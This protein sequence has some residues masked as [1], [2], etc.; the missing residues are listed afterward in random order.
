MWANKYCRKNDKA[1]IYKRI[2][3]I[4]SMLK[5]GAEAT[6]ETSRTERQVQIREMRVSRKTV[7]EAQS[8]RI[9]S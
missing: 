6:S 7:G 8:D 4:T 5:Y 2:L 1:P 9:R 3:P